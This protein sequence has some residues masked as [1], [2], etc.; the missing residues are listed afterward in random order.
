MYSIWCQNIQSSHWISRLLSRTGLAHFPHGFLTGLDVWA[1][2]PIIKTS[3]NETVYFWI[4]Y[5]IHVCLCFQFNIWYGVTCTHGS[6][7][8]VR[9]RILICGWHYIHKNLD[10]LLCDTLHHKLALVIVLNGRIWQKVDKIPPIVSPLLFL[11]C[12]FFLLVIV[13][14]ANFERD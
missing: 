8:L 7:H 11:H 6:V 3:K 2:S 4:F 10:R 13:L 5:S 1:T 9:S 14:T 12:M